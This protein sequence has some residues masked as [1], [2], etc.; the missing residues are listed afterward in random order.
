MQQRDEALKIVG[1]YVV[2][3]ALWVLFSDRLLL[4]FYPDAA[5]L[6]Y[7]QT[8][9]GW[10]FVAVTGVLLYRLIK[11]RIALLLTTRQAHTQIEE[12]FREAF[13]Q[14]AVGMAHVGL[15][16][17]WLRVND[18]LCTILGYRAEELQRRTF[19]DITH[20]DDIAASEEHRRLLLDGVIDTY[21]AEK[22]YLRKEG[23]PV[24]TEL[25]VALHRDTAGT[26]HHFISVIQDIDAR[27]SAESLAQRTNVALDTALLQ[28]VN[29]L[30]LAVE[31]RDPY[32]AGHQERTSQLAA[33]VAVRMGLDRHTVEGVRIGAQIHDLGNIYVPAEI[34]NRPGKLND[35]EYALIKA[36]PEAG[37]DIVKEA[38][39]PWP[40][41]AMLLQHHERLDG[42]GYPH[43]LKG[44]A[45]CIEARIIAVAEV[46]EAMISHRPYRP[47]LSVTEALDEL[48][49]GRGTRYDAAAVDACA[50]LI[51]EQGAPWAV[52]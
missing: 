17:R 23:T 3:A 25:T 26:P 24:W 47:A 50:D 32:T 20:P 9:K 13:E 8:L 38:H 33:A 46:F 51:E 14:A 29:T 4:A 28:L 35:Y 10:L 40:I 37:Y 49:Q 1:L 5:T 48:R 52:H 21:S 15:D 19:S 2:F 31:K 12:Q 36:H 42:S 11:R 44:D 6:D 41:Q 18:K 7:M 27:K 34:L 16:G 45:I 43:G 39:L 22:R 30:S